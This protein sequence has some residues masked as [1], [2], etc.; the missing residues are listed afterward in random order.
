MRTVETSLDR[1]EVHCA[2]L[3][4]GDLPQMVTIFP[5]T[6]IVN[7]IPSPMTSTPLALVGKH[8]L[9]FSSST[10]SRLLLFITGEPDSWSRPWRESGLWSLWP[11]VITPTEEKVSQHATDSSEATA[12]QLRRHANNGPESQKF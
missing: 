4:L 8:T 11:H 7:W 1:R 10:T 12:N 5:H 3:R 2:P 9:L 6:P